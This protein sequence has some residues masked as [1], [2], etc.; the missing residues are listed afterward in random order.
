MARKKKYVPKS[1]ESGKCGDISANIFG[2]MIQ[3]KAWNNLSNNARVLYL[4]MKLQYYGQKNIP[5]REQ[6]YF[7]F[8]KAMFTKTYPLYKNTN[9]F[10]KDRQLLIDNG[11]IEIVE[12]TQNTREKMI[13]KLSAKWREVI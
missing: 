5:N 8:N 9:Q 2:S 13:Y 12:R 10:Y 3:S 4:Y 1:F 6:E 11:F 7:Y